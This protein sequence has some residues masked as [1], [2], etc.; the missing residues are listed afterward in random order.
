MINKIDLAPMVGARLK[1]MERDTLLMRGDLP[2]CFTNTKTGEGLKIIEY[3]L[4]T[5]IHNV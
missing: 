4:C 2:W 5:Q 1:V 3:F